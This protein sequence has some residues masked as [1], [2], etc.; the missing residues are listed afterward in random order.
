M[1]ITSQED[2]QKAQGLLQS[3]KAKDPARLKSAISSYLETTNK[4]GNNGPSFLNWDPGQGGAKPGEVVATGAR[5]KPNAQ[6][7]DIDLSRPDAV[8][9]QPGET[10]G[11]LRLQALRKQFEDRKLPNASKLKVYSDPPEYEP[12][13]KPQSPFNPMSSLS[14]Q[15]YLGPDDATH[16]KYFHEPTVAEF[17]NDVA[18]SPELQARLAKDF[19]HISDKLKSKVDDNQLTSS[20]TFLAYQDSRWRLAYADAVKRGQPLYRLAYTKAIPEEEKASAQRADMANAVVGGAGQGATLGLLNPLQQAINPRM[21]EES[22][23]ERGRNPGSAFAGDIVGSMAGAPRLLFGGLS[24]LTDKI[25]NKLAS[26]ALAGGLTG[27]IDDSARQVGESVAE[28]L[29]AHD[30]ALEALARIQDRFSPMR[31]G[32]A[33]GLGAVMAGGGHLLG[34]GANRLGQ[35]I[36]T[37]PDRLPVINRNMN[38]GGTM[39]FSGSI[40]V[41]PEIHAIQSAASRAGTT[42]EDAIA[43]DMADKVITSQRLAQEE[44]ARTSA[45]ETAAAHAAMRRPEIKNGSLSMGADSRPLGPTA[46]RIRDVANEFA[47]AT[48][49]SKAAMRKVRDFADELSRRGHANIEELNKLEADADQL[50][51]N[52]NPNGKTDPAW[53]KIASIIRDL[54]DE[55]DI[56]GDATIVDRPQYAVRDSKGQE[57]LVGKYSGLNADQA[58]RMRLLEYENKTLGLPERIPVKPRQV[59]PVKLDV[60]EEPDKGLFDKLHDTT[61]ETYNQKPAQ[62]D[63]LLEGKPEADIEPNIRANAAN[64]IKEIAAAEGPLPVKETIIRAGNRSGSDFSRGLDVLRKAQDRGDYQRMLGKAISKFG[65]PQLNPNQLLRLVPTLKGLA[66]GRPT[67]PTLEATPLL[68]EALDELLRGKVVNNRGTALG[69]EVPRAGAEIMD[70]FVPELGGGILKL[71]GSKLPSM[72]GSITKRGKEESVLQKLT[73]QEQKLLVEIIGNL[74]EMNPETP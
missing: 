27:G 24:K 59:E 62:V 11:S 5:A 66:G 21:A 18:K 14:A 28:S 26:T 10:A 52:S 19:P 47:G 72:A 12:P 38:S 55:F 67:P 13:P 51:R 73:P 4:Q 1:P 46:G 29:D 31:A 58:N 17:R 60:I 30:A 54:R 22:R 48:N 23:A 42:A 70:K 34:E 61:A 68:Q 37:H 9:L 53:Q 43:N 50:A 40:N 25:P 20:D 69:K 8:V 56:P 39:G 2:F 33:T 16:K 64:R 74:A 3:G 41:E 63:A 71:G 57:K 7:Y 44:L 65:T 32:I 45:E 36:V 49:E 35:S 6:G 15:A